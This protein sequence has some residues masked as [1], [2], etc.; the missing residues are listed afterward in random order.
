MLRFGVALGVVLAAG[1]LA[2][3]D[4]PPDQYGLFDMTSVVIVDD[5]TRLNW[6][7]TP[8]TGTFNYG[9]A[10]A[11]CAALVLT[12]QTPGPDGG[13][14]QTGWR[15]PSYKEALTLV[16]ESPHTE[17]QNGKL[18]DVATDGHAF[19]LTLVDAPYWSSSIVATT[20]TEAF[21]IDFRTGVV[22]T[23]PKS[24]STLHARCVHD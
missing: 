20:R 10:V 12:T 3:A 22:E 17:Y 2:L 16:D 11:A 18:V 4:A 15:L 21:V 23:R 9:G 14:P 1:S 19:P 5:Y 6:Q 13:F 8:L 7:R 24:T